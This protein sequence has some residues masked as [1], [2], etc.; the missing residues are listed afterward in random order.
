MDDASVLK[1]QMSRQATE[2][3]RRWQLVLRNSGTLTVGF[4][5]D[6]LC[7]LDPNKGFLVRVPGIKEAPD[8]VEQGGDTLED[9]AFDR[10]SLE[11]REPRLHLVHPT[12][13]GG[14][15]VKVDAGMLAQ[16]ELDPGLLV[17]AGVI[18]DDVQL[19]PGIGPG[20]Q[21]EKCQE[22]S[23]IATTVNL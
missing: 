18:E 19:S 21:L 5:Q 23:A 17:G 4:S 16:P 14:R 1:A 9:A 15:E 2:Q 8:G 20:H 13:A 7:R 6:L 11:E 3:A 22:L 10:P 12:G